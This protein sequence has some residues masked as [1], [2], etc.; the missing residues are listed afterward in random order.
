MSAH[1]QRVRAVAEQVKATRSAGTPLQFRK[2]TVSHMVPDPYK[3]RAPEIDLRPLNHILEIDVE[4]RTC[5]A[6]SG[7]A[8]A[9]LVAETLKHG[10]VPYTVSEL[11]TITIGG[12]VS[13]CSIESMSYVHGG[14]H[15]KCL[16]Y[17]LVDGRGE[18]RTCSL[19]QDPELFHLLHGSYG[20]LGILTKL[21]F[22]LCPAK[23]YV[24]LENRLHTSFESFKKDLYERCEAGDYD[25][26]DGIIHSPRQLV[27]CLGRMVDSA[28][29][30]SRYDR[31]EIY[32]KSTLS[33]RED[34]MAITD[35]FF[36]YDTE[37]HWL[38]RTVPGL[39]NRYVRRLVGKRILGSSNLIRWSDRLRHVLK[40]VKRRPDVVVDVFIPSRRF[41]E[42]WAWYQKCYGFF[43]LWIVPYRMQEIYPWVCDEL[44]ERIGETFFMDCA[45]YGR[46][47]NDPLA[48]W[49]EILEQKVT[50]LDGVKTLIS[51]NHYSPESFW[52]TYSEPRI[53]AA[54]KRMDPDNLF[55]GLYERMV[56][57]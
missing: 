25:F 22:Q 6:E 31:E 27:L 26:V 19:E 54:K 45:V 13:G 29:R 56:R 11:K 47:N 51:R 33:K 4:A 32:Y 10:L 1:E 18:V 36:R 30:T 9:D 41:D 39:E 8:L 5:T 21:K 48:D 2:A 42:F 40:R 55:G 38:T 52:E 12:A 37:C 17:E 24:Q 15:D 49:S 20:T 16:E 35:Y 28:P 3:E 43:P 53:S 7:V 14:F 23:P 46:P 34:W 50:E 57:G 44:A